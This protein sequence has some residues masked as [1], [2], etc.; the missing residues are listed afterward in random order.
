MHDINQQQMMC[1][2]I[3][4]SNHNIKTRGRQAFFPIYTLLLQ[5]SHEASSPRETFSSGKA[6][7]YGRSHIELYGRMKH[8]SIDAN[9][10]RVGITVN[11]LVSLRKNHL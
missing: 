1:D 2:L 5:I 3:T 6:S 7:K 8:K 10:M 4:I 9:I 11:F